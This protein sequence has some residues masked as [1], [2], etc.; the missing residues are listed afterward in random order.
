M[1]SNPSPASI[2]PICRRAPARG[3]RFVRPRAA[4]PLGKAH[5]R[6]MSTNFQAG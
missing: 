5:V 6:S 2:V 3:R 1:P 4:G